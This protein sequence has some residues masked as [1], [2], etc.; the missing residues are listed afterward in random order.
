M[1]PILILD[2]IFII[3]VTLSNRHEQFKSVSNNDSFHS[4][5]GH[6]FL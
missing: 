4:K 1:K 2:Y 6:Q 3:S 5:D